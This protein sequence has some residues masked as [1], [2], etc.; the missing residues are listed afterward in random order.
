[1]TTDRPIDDADGDAAHRW[2]D[3]LAGRPGA[4][5]AHADG[6]RVRAALAPASGDA[7]V[8]TW[9]DIEKRAVA[10]SS[11]D[12]V[13]APVGPAAPVAPPMA[14]V[15]ANDAAPWRRMGWAAVLVLAAGLA[16]LM[17]SWAPTQDTALRGTEGPQGQGARWLV[18][19]PAQAAEGLAAELRALQAEVTLVREG[20]ALVLHIQA[21]PAAVPGVNARL[22]PLETGLDAHGHLQ[23]RVLPGR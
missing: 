23:L 4:G 10:D 16:A 13:A 18:D 9:H 1:M 7:V 14:R 20:D 5:A 21:E 2:L 19:R 6:E 3:G 8:G 15:A 22:A 11:P 17:W 12:A